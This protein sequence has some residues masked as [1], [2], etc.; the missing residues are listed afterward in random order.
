[1]QRAIG[2]W[3]AL[4]NAGLVLAILAVSGFGMVQVASREWW[5]QETFRLRVALA[6]IGALEAGNQVR[7][8]GIDAGAVERIE[9][10]TLPGKPVTLVLRVDAKLRPLVRSDALARVVS[11]GVVGARVVEIV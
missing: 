9:P 6:T 2:R 3:R 8:Q 5:V 10:P 1:M 7:V 11:E 4:V